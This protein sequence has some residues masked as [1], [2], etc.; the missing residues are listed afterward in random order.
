ME[1]KTVFEK[2]FQLWPICGV[3]F[4]CEHTNLF[5]HLLKY[6]VKCITYHYIK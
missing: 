3:F 4:V 2:T 6:C 1:L 5:E